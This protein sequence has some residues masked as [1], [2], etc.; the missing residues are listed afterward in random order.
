MRLTVCYVSN[1][2][3]ELTPIQI[4]SL[5]SFTQ[6]TNNKQNIHGLLLYSD[7]NFFQIIEGK[8]KYLYPLWKK[9]KEDKR[10]HSIIKIF[11]EEVSQ[12]CFETFVSDYI[13]DNEVFQYKNL[14]HFFDQLK[15]LDEKLRNAAEEVLKQFLKYH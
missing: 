6:S 9:I 4:Q 12:P 10:H 11:E 5:L 2:N 1:C 3:L 8:S 15:F 7:G 13:C 14:K